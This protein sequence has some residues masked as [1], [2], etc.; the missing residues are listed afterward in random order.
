MNLYRYLNI[1]RKFIDKA[2]DNFLPETDEYPP[3]IHK[4][5]R[6]SVFSGGKRIRPILAIA[7]C[8]AVGG[9]AKDALKPACAVELIHTFSLIHDDLPAVDNSDKRRGK[10]S[11]HK[12]YDE[13]VAILAGDALLNLAFE[14]LSQARKPRLQLEIINT[15]ARAVGTYGMIGGQV[16]DIQSKTKDI[17]LPTLQY[18]H[19]HKTGA[20]IAASLK[21]GALSGGGTKKQVEKLTRFGE[22]LGFAFQVIDDALDSQGYALLF[23]PRSA[24]QEALRLCM[25]AKV[26]L[27]H[28]GKKADV[29][30]KIADFVATRT[31]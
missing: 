2:L 12:K 21:I 8:Q 10:K 17:S 5:I 1:K 18:I 28:F 16:A 9:R 13:A 27:S 4:A 20:L 19:T 25:R 24:R 11:L 3:V 14:L 30:N 26:E 7:A 22:Y 31:A 15:L 6:Y 23:G 29:L